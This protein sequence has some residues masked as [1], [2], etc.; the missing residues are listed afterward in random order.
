MNNDNE[1][2]QLKRIVLDGY[3]S[4]KHC[5][6]ELNRLNVL[7]GANG[8]G[9]SNFIDLFK[10]VQS[11]LQQNLQ[12]HISKSGGPDALL[13]FGNKR[14]KRMNV[15]L[16]MTGDYVYKFSLESS[17]DNR[18]LFHYE[19]LVNN[20]GGGYVYNLKGHFESALCDNDALREQVFP[21]FDECLRQWR[22]YH[23]HDT[24]DAAHV[25]GLHN[26]DDNQYMHPDGG[27]LAAFLYMLKETYPKNY[28]QVVKT[29]QM[30][31]P[32]F[33]DFVLRAQ[34]SNKELI[35]L[36]WREKG[37]DNLFKAFQLSDG[38][39]RFICL[40]TVLLQP[41]ELKPETILIDEPELGL[42]PYAISL[43][44]AMMRSA[45]ATKQLIISTQ[46]ADFLD[47]F[48]PEDVIVADRVN[49]C[50]ELKRLNPE[51]LDEWLE[52]YS[53]AELWKKNVLG[54]RPA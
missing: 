18:M 7:I 30:V 35:Q 2:A 28:R 40:A 13:H 44:A 49:S 27:N 4:I 45:S 17:Q 31:A 10:L 20:A 1:N 12:L 16:R 19:Q 6:L 34:P 32:F 39:L 47:E 54:G 14:T 37:A 15:E 51:E 23:F 46:S 33:D 21:G 5:D 25:K 41:D 22:V 43:L 52:N 53:I 42:H 38:T 50:T 8:A 29:V 3:K 24:G 11:I 48:E 36:E 9:K 26:I